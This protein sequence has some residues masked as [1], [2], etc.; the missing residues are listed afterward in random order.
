MA[1]ETVIGFDFGM[2]RIGVAVGQSITGT[3]G[4]LTVLP[5]RDG[6]PDWDS[7]GA[8]ISEWKPSRVV[9]GLPLNMDGTGSDMS[10]LAEKFGRKLH[11]RFGVEVEMVDE[12][13][14]TRAARELS[15]DYQSGKHVDAIAACL[16][17]ETWFDSFG[18]S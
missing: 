17:L 13:L 11:G 12:R 2:A 6:V 4:P 8:L 15:Q 7:L 3:A 14:S 1:G 9:V 10:A 16:I 5:A 18:D